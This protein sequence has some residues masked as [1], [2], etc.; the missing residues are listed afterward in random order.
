L[1]LGNL[2]IL[3]FKIETS[4]LREPWKLFGEISPQSCIITHPSLA[5]ATPDE[6]KNDSGEILRSFGTSY[7][8]P[9]LPLLGCS[10]I[11]G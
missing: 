4:N 10:R 1:S 3:I 5:E 11:D 9:S 2:V 7:S 8:K 6:M